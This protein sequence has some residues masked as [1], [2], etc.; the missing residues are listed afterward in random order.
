MASYCVLCFRAVEG[1][2]GIQCTAECKH[3]FHY[4]CVKTRLMLKSN[5]DVKH[6]LRRNYI[7]CSVNGTSDTGTSEQYQVV[8]NSIN[9]KL[10]T[11]DEIKSE[12]SKLSKCN[13]ALEN[14]FDKLKL[15][16]ESMSDNHVIFEKNLDTQ[17]K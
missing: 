10:D 14:K 17:N 16:V 4:F 1:N 13:K 8:I 12:L 2:N 7:I 5:K 11:L 15:S 3:F 6:L 9:K